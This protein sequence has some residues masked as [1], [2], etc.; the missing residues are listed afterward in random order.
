VY[1]GLDLK[2]NQKILLD[3]MKKRHKENNKD[4]DAY[5]T[6]V[7]TEARRALQRLRKAIRSAASKA[8]EGFSYGVPA[9]KL[10]GKPL[11]CFA[12]F[13]N[14]CGFYPMS[15]AVLSRYSHELSGYDTAK[16]TIRFQPEK[17]IPDAL[18]K[19]IVK[20]RITEIESAADSW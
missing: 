14:H 9:F 19:K 1:N 7:S 11:V 12:A 8:E 2:N 13:K 17:P 5:L 18:V 15:P 10:H 6:G 16:G 3:E 20:E 4:V